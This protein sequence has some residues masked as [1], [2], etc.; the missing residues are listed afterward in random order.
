MSTSYRKYGH[1]P[2]C[3]TSVLPS[4]PEWTLGSA[5]QNLNTKWTLR[6]PS[7][8]AG[9]SCASMTAGQKWK[10]RAWSHKTLSQSGLVEPLHASIGSNFRSVSAIGTKDRQ[11]PSLQILSYTFF[12]WM[13]TFFEKSAS[14]CLLYPFFAISI[15]LCPTCR[16]SIL[17]LMLFA[18]IAPPYHVKLTGIEAAYSVA[19]CNLVLS[20]WHW[21]IPPKS[22]V[23]EK[24]TT[25]I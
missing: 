24:F 5:I 1:V 18:A 14:V 9:T 11:N 3:I 12:R 17:I 20:K 23:R 4:Y 22:I 10:W 15:S 2:S 6:K 21:F 16:Y 25:G 13:H 7:K 8:S 19:C